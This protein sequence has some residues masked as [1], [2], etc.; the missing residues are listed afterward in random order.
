MTAATLAGLVLFA[1]MALKVSDIYLGG[2]Y[3]C[4]SCGA[5]SKRGHSD[6]CPWNRAS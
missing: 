3:A 5:R 6:D 2:H 1:L 4:P